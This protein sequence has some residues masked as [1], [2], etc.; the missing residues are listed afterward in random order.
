MSGVD[1]RSEAA[2]AKLDAQEADLR[3]RA[4]LAELKAKLK[5]SKGD[6]G[7]ETGGGNKRTM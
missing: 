7:G 4:E 5:A 3:A 2:T 6:G 1:R